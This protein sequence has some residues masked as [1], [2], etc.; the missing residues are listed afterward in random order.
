ML[1]SFDDPDAFDTPLEITEEAVEKQVAGGSIDTVYQEN[2]ALE[3]EIERLRA[4]MRMIAEVSKSYGNL[5]TLRIANRALE[6]IGG[7]DG[8]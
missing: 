3:A 1:K 7:E 2:R 4:A 6:V 5:H 8:T